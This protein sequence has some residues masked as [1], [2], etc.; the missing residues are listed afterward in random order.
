MTERNI[1]QEEIESLWERSIAPGMTVEMTIKPGA[2]PVADLGE[3]G[4]PSPAGSATEP[5]KEPVDISSSLTVASRIEVREQTVADAGMVKPPP[6]YELLDILGEGGMGTV[7][8]ARQTSMDR[9]IALKM[10]RPDAAEKKRDR[11]R[12]LSEAVATG[13]LDHPNI[14]P[15]YDLGANESG[16]LFYAM[17]EVRGTPWEEVLDG[18][19]LHENLSILLRVADAVAFAHSR[20]II[21]R[22]LKPDNVM[23]GNYGEVMLTDWGLAV[24]VTEEGKAARLEEGHTV[25][26]TPSYMAPELAAGDI[27]RIGTCS[28]VYLLGAILFRIVTGHS[29]HSGDRVMECLRNAANNVIELPE[30]EAGKTHEQELLDIARRAM[31]TEP[32]HRHADVKTFQADVREYLDHAESITLTEHAAADLEKA[33]QSR[34]YQDYT[35]ALSGYKQALNLWKANERAQT[36]LKDAQLAYAHCAFDRGDF[37]LAHSLLDEGVAAHR[38]L[39]KRIDAARRERDAH[40]KRLRTFK[41]VAA[42]SAAAVLVL[43]IGA[44]VWIRNEQARTMAE[45][46]LAAEARAEKLEAE[47]AA[48]ELEQQRLE[49]WIPVCEFDFT[50]DAEL[51]ERFEALR[52]ESISESD[53]E[54][55][56]A[57]DSASIGRGELIVHG[58]VRWIGGLA[59]LRWK[60]DV[61]EDMRVEVTVPGDQFF[62]LSVA[63]D[64]LNSYRAVFDLYDGSVRP[65][66]ELDTI[67]EID[68]RMFARSRG[69]VDKTAK[70][71]VAVLEKAGQTIRVKLDGVTHI[72]YW[73]PFPFSGERHRT[74]ALGAWW[75]DARFKSLRVSRRRSPEV[76]SALEIGR[77]RMRLRRFAEAER[78]FREK[79]STHADTDMGMEAKFLLGIVLQHQGRDQEALALYEELTDL[80]PGRVPQQLRL[81]ALNQAA[82]MLVDRKEFEKACD[83]AAQA[84]R[85]NPSAPAPDTVYNRILA[86]AHNAAEQER[87]RLLAVMTRLPV[88]KWELI[89]IGLTDLPAFAGSPVTSLRVTNNKIGNLFPLKGSSITHLDCENNDIE[90]L[91]PLKGLQLTSLHFKGNKVADLSPL[92]GKQLESLGFGGNEISDLSPLKGMPLRSLYCNDNDIADVAP[93]KGMPLEHL[94]FGKNRVS[95]LAPL[96]GM[97]LQSL[98]FA[99]NEIGDL[100]PLE[101]MPLKQLDFAWNRV[102]DLSPLES[103]SLEELN[104]AENQVTNLAPLRGMKLRVL[105]CQNNR[106]SDLGPLKG[107]P[108]RL[109]TCF[110]NPISDLTPLKGMPLRRLNASHTLVRDLSPLEGMN[111]LSAEFQDTLVTNL[112]PLRGLPLQHV[113]SSYNRVSDLSP[114]EG[115]PIEILECEYALVTNLA[116]LRGMLLKGLDCAGNS[117]AD[118]SPLK[119][120]TTLESLQLGDTRVTDLSPLKGLPLVRLIFPYN[121]VSDLS[122]LKGM[123]LARLMFHWNNVSDL[124]PLRGMPLTGLMIAGN[125]VADLSS[126]KGM[127]LESLACGFT[128][129]TD[130]SPLRGAPLKWLGATGVPLSRENVDVIKSFGLEGLEVDLAQPAALSLV[131]DMPALTRVNDFSREHVLEVGRDISKALRGETVDLSRYAVAHGGVRWLAVPQSMTIDEAAA[132]CSKQGGYMACPSTEAKRGAFLSYI[133]T[134]APEPGPIFIRVGV[135]FDEASG[136]WHWATGAPCSEDAWMNK[137]AYRLSNQFKAAK[138]AVRDTRRGLI[139]DHR[140]TPDVFVIEWEGE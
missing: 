89:G 80:P 133:G 18:K 87:D 62:I 107:M 96:K 24:S 104:C 111:L 59:F 26:G 66:V 51:D 98:H 93:L 130:L 47:K 8:R 35:D 138:L 106:I 100:T 115:T 122:P 78:F 25:G 23:L 2:E 45:K 70:T 103:A 126:L 28:D 76:V 110:E 10:L 131:Q 43:G 11:D 112:A 124:T 61:G 101:A 114:L 86:H 123:P 68:Q 32:R 127:P 94:E 74:F 64:S 37:D 33:Q 91:T 22:D 135:S 92:S 34:N 6:Q 116:P 99:G 14:I 16:Q 20:G 137:T 136:K 4:E 88:E 71:H 58:K 85:I 41:T 50:K 121:S 83:K 117:I 31:A 105:D 30:K 128:R 119:G 95:D 60:E 46:H 63:G 67:A 54:L 19:P 69:K 53:R 77:E 21:H 73:D 125:P 65:V 5:A 120:M 139:A 140:H 3:I 132:F 40:V 17:K 44:F 12:F 42:V 134:T 27:T 81:A 36:G 72:E 29:P 113:D 84:F 108:L 48:S 13:D 90:D 38:S 79:C 55:L 56:P 102:S 129:V 109:L 52:C 39:A 15:V 1:T 82:H 118:L 7:F 57:P 49:S 75:A 97:P 9:P